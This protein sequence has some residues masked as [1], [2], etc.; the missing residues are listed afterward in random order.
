MNQG[1]GRDTPGLVVPVRPLGEWHPLPRREFGEY[2]CRVRKDHAPENRKFV[3]KI[4]MNRLHLSRV[5]KTRPK[6]HLRACLDS[7]Y[8]AQVPGLPA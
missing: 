1:R 2:A 5:K 4:A 7:A 3:R 6:K 8:L